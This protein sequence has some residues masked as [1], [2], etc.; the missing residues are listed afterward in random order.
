MSI[1]TEKLDT[2]IQLIESQGVPIR[3][4]LE[5]GLSRSAIEQKN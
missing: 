1:I 5:P 2:L 3:S 4:Q